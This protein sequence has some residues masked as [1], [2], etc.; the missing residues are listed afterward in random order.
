MGLTH[1]SDRFPDTARFARDRATINELIAGLQGINARADIPHRLTTGELLQLRLQVA[2]LYDKLGGGS[3]GLARAGGVAGSMA[4]ITLAKAIEKKATTS[5][6]RRA[7]TLTARTNEKKKPLPANDDHHRVAATMPLPAAVTAVVPDPA[8]AAPVPAPHLPSPALEPD[9]FIVDVVQPP[10]PLPPRRVS[11]ATGLTLLA[12][13]PQ[14][15]RTGVVLPT[16]PLAASSPG[17]L[18]QLPPLAALALSETAVDAAECTADLQVS[19]P[20]PAKPAST[21]SSSQCH[22]LYLSDLAADPATAA[23]PVV[24][25]SPSSRS[26][27]STA[28]LPDPGIGA[29]LDYLPPLDSMSMARVDDEDEADG[30]LF[31]S[32][33]ADLEAEPAPTL[34]RW[35]R[36][37]SMGRLRAWST[38]CAS[39]RSSSAGGSLMRDAADVEGADEYTRH[40]LATMPAVASS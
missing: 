13:Q 32:S 27:P 38:S 26:R 22:E 28:V 37:A 21:A 35:H 14:R 6:K 18:P 16:S 40:W 25:V 4:A 11:T 34:V 9:E 3:A 7:V 12:P 39:T 10:P 17:P 15:S 23:S 36:H 29:P 20:V 2:Q 8:V 1:S 5:G 31:F 24:V 33:L 19:V 30:V